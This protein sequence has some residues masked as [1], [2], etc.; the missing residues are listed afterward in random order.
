MSSL[1]AWLSGIRRVVSAPSLVVGVWALTTLVSLPLTLTI[2]HDIEN[3]L[4]QSLAAGA[5]AQGMNYEWMQDFGRQSAGLDTTLR[6]DVVGF[7]AVLDNLSAYVD[8]IRRPSAVAAA[9]GAYVLLWLFLA[10]GVIARYAGGAARVHGFFSACSA[11]FFRFVRLGLLTAIV[12]A[13]LFGAL[14]PWLFT[15]VYPRLVHNVNV[16]PTAFVIRGGL[17]AV[18]VLVLAAANLVFDYAKIRAV[19]EDRRSMLVAVAASWRFIVRHPAGAVG[20]Y[21]LDAA[22][23]LATLAAYA[24]VAPPGGGIGVMAWGAFVIGQAYI[25]GR[26]SVKLLFWASETVFVEAALKGPPY[27]GRT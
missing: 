13:L 3:N 27:E 25:A 22:L 26:L 7:S 23:F 4:G 15:S 9:A 21:L 17:Y 16:E 6:P 12:Y 10:G 5:A 14:Q 19:V 8:N 2:R 1:H 18:F 24:F 20:V 11:Y